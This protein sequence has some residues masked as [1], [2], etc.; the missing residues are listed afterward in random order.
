M[1]RSF[2][3]I[4]VWAIQAWTYRNRTIL[5]GDDGTRRL[6]VQDGATFNA[7]LDKVPSFKVL[8]S[9]ADR[10]IRPMGLEIASAEVEQLD[11]KAEQSWDAR[12]DFA[13]ALHIGIH[14][15]PGSWLYSGGHQA[16]LIDGAIV[17]QD[18]T[19]LHSAVNFGDVPRVHF[20]LHLRKAAVVEEPT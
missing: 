13:V 3:W 19:V 15:N 4:D 17:S 11:A 20:V 5:A 6:M 16:T 8:L 18:R 1:I 10:I 12:G 14:T 2:G 9:K 7:D